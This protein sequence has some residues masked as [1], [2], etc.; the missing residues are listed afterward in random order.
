MNNHKK[1]SKDMSAHPTSPMRLWQD[2]GG[3]EEVRIEILP[4]IDVIFC[5]LTFF[6]LGAVGLSRQQAINL[7]LPKAQTGT[8]QMQEM[9]VVSLDELGRLYLEKQPTNKTQLNQAIVNYYQQNPS[10]LV[11]LHAS[12][13]TNYSNVVEILDLLRAVG[14]DRIA[15][16]TLP[17][18]SDTGN[19]TEN[20]YNVN[21]PVQIPNQN[22]LGLPVN[23]NNLPNLPNNN[24]SPNLPSNNNPPR[25]NLSPNL[26]S[27]NNLPNLPSNNNPPRENPSPNN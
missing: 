22:N 16:A 7:D 8:S 18:E 24:N 17:G 20:Y 27:N 26:P 5:I 19:N 12:R 2:R 14:G 3:G 13:Q 21:P 1:K 10:G 25:E 15:L 6:I 9:L 11:V 4:L 23:P